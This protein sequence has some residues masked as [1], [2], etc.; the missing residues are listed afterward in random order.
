[1]PF[2]IGI[3]YGMD[4]RRG[5]RCGFGEGNRR[6]GRLRIGGRV[7][8]LRVA[9]VVRGL[10]AGNRGF[11]RFPGF[12]RLRVTRL[13]RLFFFRVFYVAHGAM[14]RRPEREFTSSVSGPMTPRSGRRR[15]IG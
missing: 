5:C 1:M 4:L 3:G 13:R 8:I 10:A 7:G 9:L 15:A 11:L 12:F 6:G 14:I 2:L